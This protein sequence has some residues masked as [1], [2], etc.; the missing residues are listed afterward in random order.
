MT[1]K[2]IVAL[3][4]NNGNKDRF[5]TKLSLE[6]DLDEKELWVLRKIY[7]YEG[8]GRRTLSIISYEEGYD[9]GEGRIRSIMKKLRLYGYIDINKGLKGTKIL[10]KGIKRVNL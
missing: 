5:E 9:I 2:Y 7:K 8:I 1:P 3:I 4:N 10:D 6:Q